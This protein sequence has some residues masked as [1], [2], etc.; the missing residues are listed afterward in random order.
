[1]DYDEDYDEAELEQ[2]MV[3]AAGDESETDMEKAAEKSKFACA[4][5]CLGG[6]GFWASLGF[7][8]YNE[9]RYVD[10]EVKLGADLHSHWLRW[11]MFF[12]NL[13]CTTMFL[14]PLY[15]AIDIM[16]DFIDDIPM[17]GDCIEDMMESAGAALLG[18]LACAISCGCSLLVF[19]I[20]WIAVHPTVGYVCL[21][22]FVL[23]MIGICVARSQA[24]PSD[25]RIA[26]QQEKGIIAK[27][28]D[29]PGADAES[30]EVDE[31]GDPIYPPPA[32]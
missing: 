7:L 9:K 18:G 12:L 10:Q 11:A 25:K 32:E 13:I 6:I 26:R 16:G 27:D 2:P 24:P 22:L 19:G 31:N 1:M 30:V 4:I 8:A 17:V 5:S 21:G 14:Y 15:S 28:V 20:V 3:E 23:A 29:A